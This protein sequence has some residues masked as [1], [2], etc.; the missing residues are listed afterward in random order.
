M[1]STHFKRKQHGSKGEMGQSLCD[2]Q[3]QLHNLQGPV[4]N[5]NAGPLI[6][7]TGKKLLL[8]FA[9]C[10]WTSRVIFTIINVALSWMSQP[11]SSTPQL[12]TYDAFQL[13]PSHPTPTLCSLTAGEGHGTTE[14]VPECVSGGTR[15]APTW[16]KVPSP[17]HIL[18]CSIRVHLLST[19]SKINLLRISRWKLQSIQPKVACTHHTPR[20]QVLVTH[21][22]PNPGHMD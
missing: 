19:D 13:Q 16:N 12:G 4:Q 3:G 2:I 20:K 21:S 15:V 22:H 7:K 1:L 14:Q 18:H 11:H 8:D 9:I 6:H 17:P 10:L 5:E